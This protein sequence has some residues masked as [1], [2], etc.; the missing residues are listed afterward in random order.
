MRAS[1]LVGAEEVG[2]VAQVGEERARLG[3]AVGRL[4]RSAR[5]RLPVAGVGELEEVA[6]G[7]AAERAAQEGGEREVVAAGGGEAQRGEQV[8]DGELAADAQE[9]G[10]GDR[11]ARRA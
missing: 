10:A 9:V 2:L 6:L 11:H 3:P 7:E 1:E 8:A 4:P 5:Q